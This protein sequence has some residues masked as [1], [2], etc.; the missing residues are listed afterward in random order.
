M[1]CEEEIGLVAGHTPNYSNFEFNASNNFHYTFKYLYNLYAEQKSGN[2]IEITNSV[3]RFI[4]SEQCESD[5]R[6][7]VRYNHVFMA[8]SGL[9][10]EGGGGGETK[11]NL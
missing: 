4:K 9:G 2:L 5:G 3:W 8:A 6:E 11:E 10:C 1:H 7:P